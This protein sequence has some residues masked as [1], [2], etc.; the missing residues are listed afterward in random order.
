[1]REK[2]LALCVLLAFTATGCPRGDSGPTTPE[3]EPEDTGPVADTEPEPEPPPPSPVKIRVRAVHVAASA[4]K[5]PVTLTYTTEDEPGTVTE[6][7]AFGTASDYVDAILPPSSTEIG[8]DLM[9]EGFE[10]DASGLSVSEG[11]SHSA[12]VYSDPE[13]RG[14]LH[15]ALFS[16]EA[17]APE[18]MRARF[19]H[20]VMG[21][22]SVDVC[23]PGENPRA[24]GGVVFAAVG[25]GGL[26]GEGYVDVPEGATR[27]QIRAAN[28]ETPCS[29]RV[30]GGVELTPPDGVE[31]GAQNLTLVAIGR[32]TGRPPVQRALLVC[33]DAPSE[34]PAC[35]RLQM[36][37]R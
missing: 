5:A 26:A 21:W 14:A 20:S 36:R 33:V 31:L 35:F 17:E 1:M 10:A 4:S 25:Y 19:F 29:G 8:L 34:T 22:D 23:T 9:A 28:E 13:E 2:L 30:L 16:D 24:A 7:L 15:I 27:L 11:A 32:A 3:P 37:A 18:G 12:L 6:A